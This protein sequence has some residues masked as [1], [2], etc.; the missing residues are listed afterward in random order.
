M[1][2]II[3]LFVLIAAL[4]S[5]LSVFS[6][7]GFG[8]GVEVIANQTSMIKSG[9]FGQNL[10][11][12][13]SDFKCAFCITDFEKIEITSL[14][15][16][17]EGTLMLAGRRVREGQQIKR[18]NIAALVFV[19]ASKTVE[20]SS[21]G[22]RIIGAGAEGEQKCVIKF[23]D[24][25]NYAPEAPSENA[26]SLFAT[27]QSEI[28]YFGRMNATDPEGDA[29]EFIIVS[30]PKNGYLTVSDKTTGKYKYTPSA[31]FTGSDKFVYTARDE[32]GNYSETVTVSIRTIERMSEATFADMT[33]R[34]EYNA[35]VAM[36]ALGIMSGKLLGDS[37]FFMPDDTVSRAEFVAMALKARG[38]RADSSLTKSF[39]DDNGDIPEALVGYVATAARLGIIDGEFGKAGLVF[40]PNRAITGYE[41]ASIIAR[42]LNLN[43]DGEENVFEDMSD[44]PVWARGGVSAMYTL[45][46]FDDETAERAAESV[47]RAEAAEYLY[48][49]INLG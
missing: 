41:A 11:F 30:Y 6:Y 10:K 17:T 49:M 16:S 31:D 18:K 2:K 14:P 48:R 22:F 38:I 21:F 34:G 13:D 26:A 39:F 27:T 25:I 1:K 35:A 43:T 4:I 40:E 7:A 3:I 5:T 33:D 28:S 29:L 37:S 36:S 20:N 47:T 45:G 44:I 42:I 12:S 32:W 24:R 46:I 23:T 9:L 15:S 8:S 19:P